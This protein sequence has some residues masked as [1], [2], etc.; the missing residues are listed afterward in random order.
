MIANNHAPAVALKGRMKQKSS[1]KLTWRESPLGTWQWR[2]R[3][4]KK[5]KKKSFPP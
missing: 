1:R 3:G 4:Y 5:K 2:Q